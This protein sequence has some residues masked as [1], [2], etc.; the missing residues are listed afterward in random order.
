[1]ASTLLGL[2]GAPRDAEAELSVSFIRR[3]RDEDA[4]DC[5]LA[6]GPNGAPERALRRLALRGPFAS[7]I[8]GCR[9]RPVSPSAT[10]IHSAVIMRFLRRTP[11]LLRRRAL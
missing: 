5:W 11:A 1:M 6:A 4:A 9:W 7:V 2:A 3:T 8:I 10:Y